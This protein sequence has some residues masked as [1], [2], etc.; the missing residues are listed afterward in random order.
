MEDRHI[1]L[2]SFTILDALNR[3][4]NIH[5]GPLVLFVVDSENKVIGSLTDGDIRRALIKGI[6][7]TE[8]VEKAVHRNFNFLRKNVNDD[9]KNIHIQ[10]ELKMKL[11]PVLDENNQIYEIINL[12]KYKTLLPVDAVL[13]AG[14]KG[15]RLRPLTEK[16]PKPLIKVG[17]KCIIDYN[18]DSL[19]SYGIKNIFVT[20]NYLGE[21]LEEHFKEKRDG[22]KINTVKEPK[23]LG[24]IGSIKFVV[25]FYNDTI[26]VMNSDL[27]TNIDYEDFYLHFKEHDA[28]M[29]VAAVPYIVKVPYGVFNL[30][31]RNIKGVTEKPTISYYA[32]AGIYLIKK[33]LLKLI[34][35][36]KFYNA[37]DFMSSLINNNYK[38][39][40]YP[41]SGYWIDIGQHDE[42]ERAKEIAKHIK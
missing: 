36:N 26:L 21:Q 22:I 18:I 6:S 3:I 37:T 34:P 31:G 30:E 25:S 35:E 11:V 2:N 41:I 32:N 4:N 42:L 13:M 9:V 33:E 39:I 38:V 19:I 10:R 16:T 12:E 24:T 23:Y 28:D 7:V 27:F 20:V 40:R 1:I 29:S 15:E 17:E 14:G 8:T 5:E